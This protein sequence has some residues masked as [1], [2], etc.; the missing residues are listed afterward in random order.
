MDIRLPN[1]TAT[2]E[3][4]QIEQIKSYLYQLVSQLEWIFSTIG[5]ESSVE[6]GGDLSGI[7][8]AIK[9]VLIEASEISNAYYEQMKAQM[10]KDFARKTEHSALEKEVGAI[11]KRLKTAEKKIGKFENLY[12]GAA[13]IAGS[14]MEIAAGTGTNI[15]I[16]GQGVYG[17]IFVDGEGTA[18]FSGSEGVS[19]VSYANGIISLAL[20]GEG[21]VFSAFSAENFEFI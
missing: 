10:K 14:S 13:Y 5:K 6:T 15:F 1:I 18:G 20:S 19:S 16:F 8:S 21:G 17:I 9:P 12:Y 11:E 2:T 7:I 4:G 3:R